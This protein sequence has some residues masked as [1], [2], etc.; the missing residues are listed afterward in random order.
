MQHGF[1]FASGQFS[2]EHDDVVFTPPEVAKA[3]V[4]HFSPSGRMLDPCRGD[5]AFHQLMDGADYCEIQEGR[6]FASQ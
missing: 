6:D 2:H 1:Q 3:M 5:G 4:G